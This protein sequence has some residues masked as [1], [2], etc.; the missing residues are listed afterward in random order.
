MITALNILRV[1]ACRIL[2]FLLLII[3]SMQLQRIAYTLITIQFILINS[4]LGQ[5]TKRDNRA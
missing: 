2:I 3:L 5:A 1:K 4:L